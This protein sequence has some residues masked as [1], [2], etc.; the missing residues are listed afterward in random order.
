MPPAHHPVVV[1]Y[2][3]QLAL[4]ELLHHRSGGVEYETVDSA[5]L[6]VPARVVTEQSYQRPD[7]A[8][9]GSG[10]SPLRGMARVAEHSPRNA[11][12]ARLSTTECDIA[13]SLN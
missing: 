12:E 13:I 8:Q 1:D 3:D 7:C 11:V 5:Q 4:D 10:E 9:A 6:P 2:P